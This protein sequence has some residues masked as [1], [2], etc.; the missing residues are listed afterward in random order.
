M[1]SIVM[2]C[3]AG[4]SVGTGHLA[5][6]RALAS[7]FD[8]E[9]VAYVVGAD[10]HGR[11][12]LTDLP[13]AHALPLD[14]SEREERAFWSG[15]TIAADAIVFDLSYRARVEARDATRRL[16]AATGGGSVRRILIDGIGVDTLVDGGDW[17]LDMVIVPY[18]GGF[19]VNPAID[20]L[21]GAQF[22]L[23]AKDAPP[24]PARDPS[25]PVRSVLVTMGGSDPYG[26]TTRVLDAL[27]PTP[28]GWA[29]RVVIGPAFAPSLAA[30]IRER[31]RVRPEI[32][33]VDKPASLA[34][35]LAAA[36]LAIAATGLTKYELAAA[37]VPSVQISIDARHA[38]INAGFAAMGT[39]LHLGAAPDVSADLIRG[40]VLDLARDPDRRAEMSRRGRT[41]IDG[42]GG[43]RIVDKIRT[44][45][46][47]AA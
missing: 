34:S 23:I 36:D 44:L 30:D 8:A 6:C 17:P 40:A 7:W 27:G 41:L 1:K 5:R 37:G 2:R 14:G 42:R 15:E 10:S 12:M 11:R 18:A 39:A 31:A 35:C 24:P 45:L 46:D 9:N 21:A 13:K 38:E 29:I 19:A 43:Q 16:I 22:F 33:I 28:A 3:D 25:R 4:H 26:L 32:E 47:A 20:T